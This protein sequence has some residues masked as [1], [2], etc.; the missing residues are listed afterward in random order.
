MNGA[1]VLHVDDIEEGQINEALERLNTK[2]K[3][4]ESLKDTSLYAAEYEELIEKAQKRY[5]NENL[6]NLFL[7]T[8]VSALK[9]AHIESLNANHLAES[10]QKDKLSDS[11][12][13]NSNVAVYNISAAD[14]GS[15]FHKIMELLDLN[16]ADV[17]SQ[18]N[19][20]VNNKR[21]LKE[22]ADAVPPYKIERFLASELGKRMATAQKTGVLKK[23]QPFVLGI[24][25]KRVNSE[26]PES[27]TVLL[28]G[29]IDAFFIEDK[30]IV[31]VDYKTDKVSSGEELLEKYKVQLDYYEEAIERITGYH[32]KESILYSFSLDTEFKR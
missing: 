5:K 6:T 9:M 30:E 16:D 10:T 21:I 17:K 8:S 7:K 25:A 28:Q 2:E 32:V 26:Y 23:E 20:F 13:D 27:E 19:K 22:W 15:A 11:D 1:K 24:A 3:F 4:F 18:I 12:N 31:L 29:I 14:R